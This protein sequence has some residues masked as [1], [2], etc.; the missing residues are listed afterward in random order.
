MQTKDFTKELSILRENIISELK[1]LLKANNN[2]INIPL[3]VYSPVDKEISDLIE[4]GFDI[5]VIDDNNEPEFD[6]INFRAEVCDCI[7]MEEFEVL[8]IEIRYKE[9]EVITTQC[10]RLY[11]S[12]II[13]VEDMITI[14]NR[15]I[16]VLQ[17]K[18]TN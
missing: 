14:Y 9:I 12:D 1:N 5:C 6:N 15:V 18:Q 11:F 16:E 8:A 2:K 10:G 13:F 4:D 17:E 7:G 3:W